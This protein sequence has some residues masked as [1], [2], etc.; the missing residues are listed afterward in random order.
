MLTIDL[1]STLTPMR[2]EKATPRSYHVGEA[3]VIHKTKD[4][5][6]GLSNMASGYP[7]VVNGISLLT[8][9][10]LYQA[11]RFP[12]LPEVQLEIIAQH[13]PMTAKIKSRL[14]ANDSRPD[15][16]DVRVRVMQWCLR[17]KL[18]QHYETFGDLLLATGDAPLVEQSRSD[19]FW[20]AKLKTDGCE[21]V[22]RNVLG[23]LLM[24]LRD[25]R[26]TGEKE[27]LITVA[28]IPIPEFMLLSRPI[29]ALTLTSARVT[30]SKKKQPS[31]FD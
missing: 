5:F 3:V 17:V 22:G 10:A 20:G 23:R 16:S 13:S 1:T 9:E 30:D 4:L 27:D 31:L 12:H 18:A 24:A 8:S 2:S 19:D 29:G 7:L 25:L 14:R 6:G 26:R 21:L 11:C 15:W 28:P